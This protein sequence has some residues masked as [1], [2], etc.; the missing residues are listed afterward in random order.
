MVKAYIEYEEREEQF[1]ESLKA[2]N[3]SK[4]ELIRLIYNLMKADC[5]EHEDGKVW[6]KGFSAYANGLRLLASVGLFEIVD[7]YERAVVGRFKEFKLDKEKLDS[8]SKGELIRVLYWILRQDC[9]F[10]IYYDKE[11]AE[12]LDAVTGEGLRLL[13]KVELV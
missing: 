5:G 9:D 1:F 3:V 6:S 11:Y 13:S 2:D 12:S 10:T 4:E 7:E 8:V